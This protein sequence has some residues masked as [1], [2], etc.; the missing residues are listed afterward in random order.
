[1]LLLLDGEL[2]DLLVICL[3]LLLEDVHLPYDAGSGLGLGVGLGLGFS[4]PNP[5]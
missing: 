5:N 2:R 3:H 1:M 4:N